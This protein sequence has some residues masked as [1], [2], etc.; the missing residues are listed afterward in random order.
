MNKNKTEY[1]SSSS[2]ADVA[3]YS[4]A[5]G[6]CHDHKLDIYLDVNK[7]MEDQP[8]VSLTTKVQA[9]MTGKEPLEIELEKN[10]KKEQK[11][12]SPYMKSKRDG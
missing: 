7:T 1:F 2:I 8:K 11:V 3:I 9:K 10:E 12:N 6:L 4:S 5:G